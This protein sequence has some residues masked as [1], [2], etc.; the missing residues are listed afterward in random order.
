[1]LQNDM[2]VKLAIARLTANSNTIFH[3][4]ETLCAAMALTSCSK[5][6]AVWRAFTTTR[7]TESLLGSGYEKE[8]MMIFL[9]SKYSAMPFRSMVKMGVP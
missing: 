9:A 2:G 7:F 8:E 5:L 3:K 1:M 4:N 6:D